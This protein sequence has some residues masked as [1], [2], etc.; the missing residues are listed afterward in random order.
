LLVPYRQIRLRLSS[1]IETA[2]NFLSDVTLFDDDED[3]RC[4]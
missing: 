3:A 1:S 2:A 4:Q